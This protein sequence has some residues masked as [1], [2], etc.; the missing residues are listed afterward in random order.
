MLTGQGS[1]HIAVSS[2][3]QGAYDYLNKSDV[4]ASELRKTI[5]GAIASSKLEKRIAE[6]EK[7]LANFAKV[8]AHDLK[9]PAN[10]I[11]AM[12]NIILAEHKSSLEEPVL[13]KLALVAHSAAQM[14]GL[15]QALISYTKLEQANPELQSVSLSQCVE[16]A[17]HNLF[18]EI[19]SRR[20]SLCI[21]DLPQV[22]VIPVLMTQLFQILLANAM[23]YNS[24]KPKVVIESKQLNQYWQISVKDNGI[25][26]EEEYRKMVFEPMFRLHD[27]D[28]YKGT[29][30]GL[31]TAFRIVEKHN[32][33]ISCQSNEWGGTT[34]IFTLP[35]GTERSMD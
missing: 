19:D 3:K 16:V 4:K 2:L 18:H 22:D 26:I 1:E 31:A 28:T 6:Q 27:S 29:G 17:S 20:A 9:Q 30:L 8:L 21:G 34:F 12:I 23:L 33:S 13:Q 5:D 25:G 32:G 24:S 7:E 10:A 11:N 35:I 15:V 14:S